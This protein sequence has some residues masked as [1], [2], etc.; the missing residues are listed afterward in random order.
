LGSVPVKQLNDSL[1]KVAPSIRRRQG[2]I[3]GPRLVPLL[4]LFFLLTWVN[5]CFAPNYANS[6]EPASEGLSAEKEN[7]TKKESGPTIPLTEEERAWLRSHPV[8]SVT[9]DPGWPPIEFTDDRGIPSG[10]S[11][12]YL[13]IVEQRLGVTFQ[14]VR[15]LSWQESY[16]RL[17][18][19]DIDMTT[20]VA[21]TPEREGFWAFTHP[22]LRIPIVILTQGDVTYISHMRELNG[23]TVGVVEG[24]AM[25]DWIPRDFPN[26]RIVKVQS[27]KEGIETVQQGRVFAFI[28]NMLVIS[29]HLAKLKAVNVKIAGD[30]PYVN[31]QCMA[32]RKDWSILAGILQKVLDSIPEAERAEIYG[33][34]VPVRYEHGF[35]YS[36][37]W[38]AAVVVLLI[39]VGMAL[40]NRQLQ[41]EITTRKAAEAALTESEKR[42]RELFEAT[43]VPLY[44]AGFDGRL[45][46][47]NRRFEETFGYTS[48]DVPTLDE[49]WRLACPDPGYRSSVLA[50]IESARESAG[51]EDREMSPI[52]CN[53]VCKDG[54]VGTFVM[55]GSVLDDGFIAAFFD[56]TERTMAEKALADEAVRKRILIEQSGDG[57][58]ILNQDGGVYETNLRFA[59]MIGYTPE[60]VS[61]LSVWDWEYQASRDRLMEMLRDVDEHGDSFE[62]VHR[63]KDGSTYSVDIRTNAAFF[64]GQKLIFCVCRDITK[65]KEAEELHERLLAAIEQTDD[66]VVIT[67]SLG[68]IQYVNPA[69]EKILGYERGE[70]I[71]NNL[72]MFN[73]DQKTETYD[74]GLWKTISTGGT[75]KGRVVNKRKNGTSIT[76]AASISPVRDSSGKIVNFVGVARD[77]TEQLHL[78]GQ[79]EQAQRMESVG[80]LA[81]GVAHDYNN[82][83]SVILGYTELAMKKMDTGSPVYGDLVEVLKAANRS[84]DITRRLL[85]FARKQTIMP[86]ILDLNETIESMLK[87]LRR[88]IGEDID[89]EWLPGSKLWRVKMDPSQLN[90]ILAN[91]AINSRDAITDVGKITIKTAN[92]LI[93]QKY[94]ASHQELSM[95]EFVRLAFSD[96]GCGM[97]DETVAQIF[98]PFFTTKGVGEG[99]GLGLSTVYGIVKQNDGFIYADSAPG[100]GTTFTIYLKREPGQVRSETEE[101]ETRPPAGNGET[102]LVVEDDAAILT[103]ADKFLKMLG[104]QV[105]L[106]QNPEKARGL[107]TQYEGTIHLLI[108]DVVL[109]GMNG[110]ELADEILRQRPDTKCLFMSG[111][112]ANAIAHRGVLD[113]GVRFIQK[114]FTLKD[115]AVKVKGV[116][117]EPS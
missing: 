79:L 86:K 82:V 46:D 20:S 72:S 18:K 110:K 93:D 102:V 22:Y 57:I 59:E 35:D 41:K 27:V 65:K 23:K 1:R 84:A 71:G 96:D 114:P 37:L 42:H 49:W 98:E 75:W 52:E 108:T 104:Y 94:R 56:V 92:I 11:A 53:L 70:V 116:L 73:S 55:W 64:A 14:R 44:F 10:I 105:F 109:P 117:E 30:T 15:N 32:V 51:V 58:V 106:A 13:G 89:L 88:L 115:F 9:E 69:F 48:S 77:M 62:T 43:A 38:Q 97:D 101:G 6:A 61:H 28:D 113:E 54:A 91:L 50:Q 29:Y 12:D 78:Q 39:V 17:K 103:M 87:M 68:A 66:T 26:I 100:K 34:W 25:A 76:V 63:R 85:A 8:I 99:T 83:L 4:A 95:G 21:V 3:P 90:Q 60:E 80:R 31:A 36:L 107:S 5:A 74:Q 19:W 40:W 2:R 67:D 111:Y 45:I 33:K 7:H 16:E 47:L 24:Y 112:T 81:G